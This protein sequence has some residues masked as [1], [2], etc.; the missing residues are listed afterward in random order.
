MET[1][2]YR[3]HE[4]CPLEYKIDLTT[5]MDVFVITNGRAS[6]EYVVKS[7][8]A[9]KNVKFN[10]HI[11][12]DMKW[13][14]AC[15]TCLNYSDTPFYLRLDDDMILHPRTI[16]FFNYFTR[17]KMRDDAVIYCLKLWEPWNKRLG[18]KV[19][20][21]VRKLTKEIGFETDS[22]GKVDKIFIKKSRQKNYKII[23]DKT[24]AIGIHAACSFDDNYRYSELRGELND[25]TFK[26]RHKEIIYLNEVIK[27]TPLGKQLKLADKDLF[28]LNKKS[29]T[30]FYKFIKETA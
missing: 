17:A 3:T 19:K 29:N 21:Y 26:I 10:F 11:I 1:G 24:S 20:V 2:I 4:I 30:L 15:Y 25:P 23:G 9:Q 13:I 7:L 18:G 14:D 27:H 8:Q 12:K 16:E 28:K 6:F 22:R 5:F